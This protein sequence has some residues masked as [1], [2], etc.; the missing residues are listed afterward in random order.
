MFPV[1]ME[2]FIWSV[3]PVNVEQVPGIL[4]TNDVWRD[5]PAECAITI[6]AES[7]GIS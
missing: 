3:S 2:G 5:D 1:L 6:L 7:A 4:S